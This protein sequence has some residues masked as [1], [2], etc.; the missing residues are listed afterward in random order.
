MVQR[1]AHVDVRA[2][3]KRASFSVEG[4]ELVELPCLA[5]DGFTQFGSLL[6]G[7]TGPKYRSLLARAGRWLRAP[8]AGTGSIREC[9]V[10]KDVQPVAHR[11]WTC[12]VNL[13]ARL[14]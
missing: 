7:A 10:I 11:V 6:S 9:Q 1:S 12:A 4:R 3:M 5:W 13:P 14:Q 8:V 2:P